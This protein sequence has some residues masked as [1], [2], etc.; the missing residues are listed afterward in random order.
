MRKKAATGKYAIITG[1]TCGIGA[2]FARVFAA[3][4]YNLLITGRRTKI[5]E[6]IALELRK[7]Y[8]VTV[9]P[10]MLELSK[11]SDITRLLKA[12]S[13]A[14]SVEVLVNNAGFGCQ[15][16]FFED[17]Y[18]NQEKMLK[19]HIDAT[20]RITHHTVPCM[21]RNGGGAIINV[22][23]LA[24]FTPLSNNLFYSASKAF[25]TTFSE[26]LHL[27]LAGKNIR[28]QAL[29]PGFT[30]TE[31]HSNLRAPGVK[32]QGILSMLWMTAEEVVHSSIKSLKSGRKVIHIPGFINRCI[33]LAIRLVPRTLYYGLAR[34]YLSG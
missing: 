33:L 17:T 6:A 25:L 4:G 8:S 18:A 15:A 12:I 21:L 3:S 29:C 27:G 2:E 28:V 7:K 23:S 32:K 30:K 10:L 14:G 24:A 22:S 9:Y 1:A 34:K 31:F 13:L 20:S 19:V 5:L 26:C 11:K 16:P